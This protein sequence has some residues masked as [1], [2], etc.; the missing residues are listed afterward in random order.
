MK[1]LS[2]I[3]IIVTG[4]LLLHASQDFPD[5]GDAHSPANSNQISQHFITQT[6]EQTAVPNFVTAVLADYR[7]FDTLFETI[8]V[9]IAGIAI[10]AVLG[11]VRMDSLVNA[12]DSPRDPTDRDII[13]IQTCR[14][15]TPVIQLFALY[16]VAHGHHS[17]G[18]GFQG[19][20]IFGASL[21]LMAISRDLSAALKRISA[22]RAFIL[23]MVGI[24]IYAGIGMLCIFMGGNF[25]D[26]SVLHP[27]LPATD[28]VMARSHGMLGVEIGVAF[29]V[30]TIM[31][32][33][34]AL[35][36]SGGRLKG[37]L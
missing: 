10:M 7:G 35:L 17:P 4:I 27:L 32:A 11:L 1:Y 36:S 3:I 6:G 18:G 19:G 31:F 34:Y 14:V 33:I 22:R 9:F 8:V 26:Y 21:I 30:S 28:S 13:V 20:V 25:L 5:W 29:T 37:G 16:V 12:P 23:A 2:L 24:L 15:I